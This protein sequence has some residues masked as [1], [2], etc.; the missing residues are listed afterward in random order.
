MPDTSDSYGNR[1]MR[2]AYAN[3][4]AVNVISQFNFGPPESY[5]K[6]SPR[7]NCI[8]FLTGGSLHKIQ[9]AT[10]MI[11]THFHFQYLSTGFL[12]KERLRKT[13]IS[14]KVLQEYGGRSLVSLVTDICLQ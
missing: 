5:F 8:T 6:I 7:S 9:G 12:F 13:N 11:D 3:E 2:S 14:N 1:N 10:R 4:F